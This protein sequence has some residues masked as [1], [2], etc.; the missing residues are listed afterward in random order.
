MCLIFVHQLMELIHYCILWSVA[1]AQTLCY[2][3]PAVQG[4]VH[5]VDGI[6][7]DIEEHRVHKHIHIQCVA[8][9]AGGGCCL[10]LNKKNTQEINLFSHF[11]VNAWNQNT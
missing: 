6:L 5:S 9:G 8:L 10:A 3:L 1:T 2:L 7:A 4:S 11:L